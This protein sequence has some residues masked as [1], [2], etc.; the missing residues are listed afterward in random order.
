[1]A[2]LKCWQLLRDVSEVTC[3]AQ[4]CVQILYINIR[5]YNLMNIMCTV[6]YGINVNEKSYKWVAVPKMLK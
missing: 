5:P 1:M 6:I 2:V 4:H 3:R